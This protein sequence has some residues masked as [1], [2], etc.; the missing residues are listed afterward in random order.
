M[1]ASPDGP[2]R[3]RTRASLFPDPLVFIA[4]DLFEACSLRNIFAVM[5]PD[6][7]LLM[8]HQ[9]HLDE[10]RRKTFVSQQKYLKRLLTK[11]ARTSRRHTNRCAWTFLHVARTIA[12]APALDKDGDELHA[13]V[14]SYRPVLTAQTRTCTRAR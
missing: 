5:P 2:T 10:L 13:T 11:A 3:V 14:S 12:N 1:S 7:P 8:S 4:F 6:L 9:A